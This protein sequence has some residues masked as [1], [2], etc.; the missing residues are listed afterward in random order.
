MIDE[1]SIS[2]KTLFD[3]FTNYP[4]IPYLSLIYEIPQNA[5]RRA[6]DFEQ[7]LEK[8]QNEAHGKS[9]I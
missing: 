4:D 7:S 9:L 3:E 6:I 8:A 1:Y 5:I 2:T